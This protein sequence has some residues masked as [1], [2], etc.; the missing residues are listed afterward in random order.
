MPDQ[1][2]H[3]RAFRKFFDAACQ[4]RCI[5]PSDK[6]SP[7]AQGESFVASQSQITARRRLQNRQ[8]LSM[9]Y[10]SNELYADLVVMRSLPLTAFIDMEGQPPGNSVFVVT[11]INESRPAA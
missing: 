1:L 4:K 8:S 9:S 3:S 5:T 10:A 6:L 7:H 11:S 2:R